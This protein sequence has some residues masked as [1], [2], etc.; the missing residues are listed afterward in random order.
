MHEIPANHVR[1]ARLGYKSIQQELPLAEFDL[2]HVRYIYQ[3]VGFD[4]QQ[5]V[6][7]HHQF[8]AYF[9]QMKNSDRYALIRGEQ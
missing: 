8:A 5:A 7:P 1:I 3:P 9:F 2:C 4:D 6:L